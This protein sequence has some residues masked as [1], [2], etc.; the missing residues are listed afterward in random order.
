M[1][2]TP[3]SIDWDKLKT[4]PLHNKL[5]FI[6]D[7][8]GL[9]PKRGYNA[10]HKY[11]Y[12]TEGDVLAELRPLMTGLG[13]LIIPNCTYSERE[14]TLTT[15][16]VEYTV[17]DGKE[18]IVFSIPGQGYDSNDKGV[19]KA[20]TGS[21]KYALMKLFKVET[22]DDPERETHVTPER[23]APVVS[24]ASGDGYVRGG[25][26]Q[27]ATSTQAMRIANLVGE[28]NWNRTRFAEW[29]LAK[30]Y[31]STAI[32]INGDERADRSSIGNAILGM[33]EEQAGDV[34][35]VLEQ[36]LPN[37]PS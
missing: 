1:E 23:P 6:Q 11:N 5:I 14:G 4:A 10:H 7:Q 29:L 30:A 3:S 17:T 15:V 21:M 16:V 26:S 19:Y 13:I 20:L 25:H 18:S 34:I 33:S 35:K 24:E 36:E 12:V 9:I 8:L 32:V 28:L 37:E 27:T 2:P 22:G 31:V